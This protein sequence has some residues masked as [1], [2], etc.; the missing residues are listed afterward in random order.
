MAHCARSWT[1]TQIYT[2]INKNNTI[3]LEHDF[4]Q[5]NNQ[6]YEQED[7]PE[8]ED[9]KSALLAEIIYKMQ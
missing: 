9:P 5:Y 3:V 4:L 6:S 2:R 8:M 7:G 1:T